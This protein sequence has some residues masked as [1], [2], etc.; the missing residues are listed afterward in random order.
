MKSK[1]IIAVGCAVLL[2]ASILTACGKKYLIIQSASG[3]DYAAVTDDSG[4]T[5]VD[6]VG[7]VAVYVTDTNDLVVTDESGVAQTNYIDVAERIVD[8][9][10]FENSAFRLKLPS[11]W[12]INANGYCY[13]SGTD[14]KCYIQI[15]D[16]GKLEVGESFGSR[17]DSNIATNELIIEKAKETY[18]DASMT[19][20]NTL[21]IGDNI[22]AAFIT[23]TIKD[24]SGTVI[25]HAECIYFY[26]KDEIYSI[27][28]V[29]DGGA[30][31][32]ASFDYYD[33]IINN[34]SFR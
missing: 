33:T 12:D 29:N 17:I 32:D 22:P 16:Q 5:V 6:S 28:L 26:Y 25:H 14:D 23:Y 31:Y 8:G 1:K 24:N 2:L 19:S 34:L 15:S 11:G 30:G 7:M 4:S 20:D 18:P 3:V 9:Q 13:K 10:T 27:N 21:V